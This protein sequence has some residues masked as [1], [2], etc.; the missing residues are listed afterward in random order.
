[1]YYIQYTV[2]R[3]WCI[4]GTSF[5]QKGNLIKT[6]YEVCV[7]R[8]Q[9]NITKWCRKRTGERL[10]RVEHQL[11]VYGRTM[12]LRRRWLHT[13]ARTKEKT[14]PETNDLGH[15]HWIVSS[16]WPWFFCRVDNI[17]GSRGR[18]KKYKRLNRG[19]VNRSSVI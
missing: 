3:I 8:V 16:S 2:F 7:L 18:K 15:D 19:F 5:V 1:M 12:S 11:R 4:F 14:F 9:Y 13:R 10:K 17:A 6:A